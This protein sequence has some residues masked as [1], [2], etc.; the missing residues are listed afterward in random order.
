M[1]RRKH[2]ACISCTVCE[3][4]N[5]TVQLCDGSIAPDID[6]ICQ[7]CF[8]DKDMQNI[9]NNTMERDEICPLCSKNK[10]RRLV[11]I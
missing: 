4:L 8:E 6:Y 3:S 1:T 5:P 9:L 11:K 10:L 2:G 7:K